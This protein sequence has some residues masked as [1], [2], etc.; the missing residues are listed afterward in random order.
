[1]SH[2]DRSHE[3]VRCQSCIEEGTM[4]EEYSIL[5]MDQVSYQDLMSSSFYKF[6]KFPI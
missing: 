1:M 2:F 5:K 3:Q 4:D 6:S